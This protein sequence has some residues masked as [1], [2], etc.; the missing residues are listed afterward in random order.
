MPGDTDQAAAPV[1]V[2]DRVE[3]S[4][5]EAVLADELEGDALPDLREVLRLRDQRDI[6]VAVHVDEAGRD[7][8]ARNVD[9]FARRERFGR[10][11][12]DDAVA[13]D[14]DVGDQRFGAQPLVDDAAP[15]DQVNV[16]AWLRSHPAVRPPRRRGRRAPRPQ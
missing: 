13:R 15:Q 9:R 1:R 7:A 6:R 4:N 11:D 12:V 14:R 10:S 16:H 8:Q 3:R 2:R 5:T